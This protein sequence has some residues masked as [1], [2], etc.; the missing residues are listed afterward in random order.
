VEVECAINVTDDEPDGIVTLDGVYVTYVVAAGV[1]DTLDM[2][3]GDK[4][5]VMLILLFNPVRVANRN[6]DGD[7]VAVPIYT[8]THTRM[9]CH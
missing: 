3:L 2:G 4:L 7:I 5:T 6:D 9:P 8:Y 1:K